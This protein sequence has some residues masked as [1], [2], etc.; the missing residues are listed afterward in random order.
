M[1]PL[2]SFIKEIVNK[3]LNLLS[4]PGHE[5]VLIELSALWPIVLAC[6]QKEPSEWRTKGWA[7]SGL[8]RWSPLVWG[9]GIFASPELTER[10]VLNLFCEHPMEAIDFSFKT[11]ER[12]RSSLG[13]GGEEEG[14]PGLLTALEKQIHKDPSL[15]LNHGDKLLFNET[16]WLEC[17]GH[18]FEIEK[19]PGFDFWMRHG[20][21]F[22]FQVDWN[23]PWTLDHEAI[24]EEV[25][26]TPFNEESKKLVKTL[27]VNAGP[28]LAEIKP[29]EANETLGMAF[30]RWFFGVSHQRWKKNLRPLMATQESSLMSWILNQEKKNKGCSPGPLSNIDFRDRVSGFGQLH[31]IASV[32][33]E[34]GYQHPMFKKNRSKKFSYQDV[35]AWFNKDPHQIISGL[36]STDPSTKSYF[37]EMGHFLLKSVALSA[38]KENWSPGATV[39]FG[40]VLEKLD[41]TDEDRLAFLSAWLSTGKEKA[42]WLL[43][44]DVLKRHWETQVLCSGKLEFYPF[45]LRQLKENDAGF[46]RHLLK[47][48]S[49]LLPRSE[50]WSRGAA[51]VCGVFSDMVSNKLQQNI[52]SEALVPIL[53]EAMREVDREDGP[54]LNQMIDILMK[55]SPKMSK[56][57]QSWVK[58]FLEHQIQ[59]TGSEKIKRRL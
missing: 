56:C 20:A 31:F 1:N 43:E 51:C 13:R 54:W 55:C 3:K 5:R 42:S 8:S 10:E 34:L 23:Q 59:N 45:L 21:S 9:H 52:S 19:C 14:V 7:G 4:L 40:D 26:L 38:S 53:S 48:A 39:A 41:W 2:S 58:A 32:L 35:V 50:S 6:A 49:V 30:C 37:N 27:S 15:W 44:N 12:L 16:R 17:L 57:H 22:G 18:L 29:P 47:Q 11:L 36:V 28:E 33:L 46:N 25:F 24:M